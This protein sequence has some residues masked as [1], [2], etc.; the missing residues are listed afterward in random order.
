M[1]AKDIAAGLDGTWKETNS[2]TLY[3]SSTKRIRVVVE[4][5]QPNYVGVFIPENEDC[6]ASDIDFI[7]DFNLSIGR[8]MCAAQ[9]MQLVESLVDNLSNDSKS[10][11]K[12][13][14]SIIDFLQGLID[15][16]TAKIS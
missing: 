3:P 10:Y 1:L 16:H 7:N 11:G 6:I 13:D 15:K 8:E 2:N 14:N 12:D 5:Y 9:E 4:E